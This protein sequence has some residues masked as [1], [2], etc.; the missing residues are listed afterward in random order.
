MI[1]TTARMKHFQN[2]IASTLLAA[3]V[4]VILGA[5]PAIGWAQ[6]DAPAP[7]VEEIDSQTI[8]SSAE[9]DAGGGEQLQQLEQIVITGSR[10]RRDTFS[11]VSPLQIISGQISREVGLTNAADI[12]QES[13]AASGQQI[14]L[15]FGGYVL[16]NGPGA[17]TVSLRGLGA[18]R[19]LALVNGRRLAPGG[20]EGAPSV[21]DLNTIPASLVQ[22]YDLLLDG[23][24]SVYGSDAIAGVANV[25]LRKD[26]DGI[27]MDLFSTV[28]E[29]GN[30]ENN[31]LTMSW[32]RNFDRG[33]V[34]VGIEHSDTKRVALRDRPWTDK[35]RTEYEVDQ[36][37][38]IRTEDLWYENMLGMDLYGCALAGIGGRVIVR[39]GRL[40]TG[41][42]YHTPGT[43]NGL[44]KNFSESSSPWG[45]F[46]VD[47]NGDGVTDINFGDYNLNASPSTQSRDLFPAFDTSTFMSYGE[48]T[49]DGEANLTPYYE[50]LYTTRNFFSDQTGLLQIF[51]FVPAGNPF[52]PCNPNQPDGVDCGLAQDALATNP[53]YVEDY[54]QWFSENQDCGGRSLELCTPEGYGRLVGALGP[55]TTQPV[56]A[57][58]GDRDNTRTDTDQLRLVFGLRGDLP[59]VNFGPVSNWSF[60]SFVSYSKSTGQSYRKGIRE[61]RLNLALGDYSS[62]NTPCEN[63]LGEELIADVAPGCVPVNMFAPSLHPIGDTVGEFATQ[64]EFDY[65]IDS[66]DFD[67]VY[68]Q[69]IASMYATGNVFELPAGDVALGFGVELRRD[70]IDSIPD[71]VA[72]DGLLWG[73]FSDGGAVGQKDTKEAFV[74]IELPLL[75]GMRLA[76]E[77]TLNLSTR[78]TNDEIYGNNWTEAVK[79]GYR[80]FNSLLLRATYGTAYRAP[81]L[82]ELFLAGTTSF[83]TITDPCYVPEAALGAEDGNYD[84]ANDQRDQQLLDNCRANGV[85]P[86]LANDNGFNRF[87]TEVSAGGS[88]TLNPEE[89]ESWTAGF[90]WDQPFTNAFNL[91]FSATYYEIDVTNTIIEP[92]AQFII[93]DCYF[94]QTGSS[95]FCDRINRDFSDPTDPRIQLLDGAFLNRDLEGARGI[96]VNIAFN[97]TWTVFERPINV[98]VDVVAN[99]GLGRSTRFTNDDGTVD[100]DEFQGEWNFPDWTTQMLARFEY[101]RWRLTWETRF[102]RHVHQDFRGVDDYGDI[103]VSTG[104]YAATCLGP[105]YGDVLCRN[106][107][108]SGNYFLNNMSLYYSADRWS[109]GLG[110]RNVFDEWPP[111]VDGNEVFSINNTP[112]GAGYDLRGRSIFLDFE[113]SFGGDS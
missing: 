102:R 45:T 105:D 101:D 63:D 100:E 54:T 91:S 6:D 106:W 93:N 34:G 5:F 35:C 83:F 3:A 69:T 58:R 78:L 56:V 104:A 38:Q 84:P 33:F 109:A 51:P 89:S 42:I 65:L 61:D 14:D 10:L 26:F 82:R 39:D 20:V 41:S 7:D 48:Y 95:A 29:H 64:Q 40:R 74:E 90:A 47:A 73:F 68:E 22:Q 66:R 88:S 36:N 75:G 28:P 2:G 111:Q 92:G 13:T 25:I 12:L 112:I 60:D 21:P 59:A 1:G 103:Y 37:G 98:G 67:T 87:S 8:A 44:W 32:G 55:I 71:A 72:R 85:D 77:L 9:D 52:N 80:P 110:I 18:G 70:A 50:A 46:G 30:G 79:V 4:L 113:F 76:E 31:T 81:N 99:R 49:L 107:G 86:T 15:T 16:D 97:D 57:V 19:T 23:A 27:E 62:T 108:D 96:D 11:S 43:S 17:S 94:S 24:S 53:N